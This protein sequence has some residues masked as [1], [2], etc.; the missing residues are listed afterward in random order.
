MYI[1]VVTME[2]IHKL[3]KIMYGLPNFIMMIKYYI[4][5]TIILTNLYYQKYPYTIRHYS[6]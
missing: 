3:I 1:K 6:H 4:L 5:Y 2:F